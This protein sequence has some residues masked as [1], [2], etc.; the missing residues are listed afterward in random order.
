[1]AS[2][3]LFAAPKGARYGALAQDNWRRRRSFR[4]QW[5]SWGGRSEFQ[6]DDDLRQSH[7]NRLVQTGSGAGDIETE[8]PWKIHTTC[9]IIV[10]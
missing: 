8:D 1:M 10:G 7:L 5:H 3:E 4:R 2:M 9:A 6:F